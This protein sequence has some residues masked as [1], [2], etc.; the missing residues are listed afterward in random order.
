VAASTREVKWG[1][2]TAAKVPMG[3]GVAGTFE[4]LPP[5]LSYPVACRWRPWY[6]RVTDRDVSAP[7]RCVRSFRTL[8]GQSSILSLTVRLELEAVIDSR[9]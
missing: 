8:R 9:F 7:P 2:T 1:H 6:R 4:W 3:G 5:R